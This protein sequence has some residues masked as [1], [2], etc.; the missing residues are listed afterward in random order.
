[1]SVSFFVPPAALVSETVFFSP[2]RVDF[3]AIRVYHF[4]AAL[5]TCLEACELWHRDC[6]DNAVLVHVS[7]VLPT[8]HHEDMCL[9]CRRFPGSGKGR[10]THPH[11]H[12]GAQSRTSDRAEMLKKAEATGRESF[13]LHAM[14]TG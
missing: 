13:F 8:R 4:T 9:S 10:V 11:P 12:T 14:L 5:R 2:S 7:L 1:M 3:S 6:G